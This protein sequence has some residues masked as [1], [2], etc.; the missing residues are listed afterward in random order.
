MGM[1]YKLEIVVKVQFSKFFD[2]TGL[3][4]KIIE[5]CTYWKR[6]IVLLPVIIG[7]KIKPKCHCLSI[8]GPAPLR[9]SRHFS[10]SVCALFNY[11]FLGPVLPKNI[12]NCT[13]PITLKKKSKIILSFSLR[14]GNSTITKK[15]LQQWFQKSLGIILT[16]ILSP[17]RGKLGEKWRNGLT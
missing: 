11:L 10:L 3:K 4:W 12:E 8:W 9:K 6:N 1:W 13:S 16:V 17:H 15:K 14:F 5:F 7:S 2:G